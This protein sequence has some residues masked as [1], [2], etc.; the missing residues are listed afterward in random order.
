MAVWQFR[1]ELIPTK[2]VLENSNGI[3]ILYTEGS[4]DSEPAWSGIL[5]NSIELKIIDKFYSRYKGWHQDHVCWGNE[6]STD[7]QFWQNSNYVESLSVR[8]DAR[9]NINSDI[10]NV[11][12][13]AKEF[14][15][16]L[17]LPEKKVIIEPNEHEVRNS[18]IGSRSTAFA[19]DPVGFLKKLT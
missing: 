17:F 16:H 6:E 2:W 8:V 18:I 5:S 11:A 3:E 19:K 7:I 14:G 1:I 15:C 4:Y 10:L 13:I 12:S 9:G